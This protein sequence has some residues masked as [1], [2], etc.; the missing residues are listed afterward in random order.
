MKRAQKSLRSILTL[1][2]LAFTIVP[3]A[4]IS[5]YTLVL[6]ESSLNSELKKRLE[7]NVREVGVGLADLE[8]LIIN[9]A[10]NIHAV[11]P[12]LS[13]HVATRNIQSARRTISEWLR[14]PSTNRIVLFDREGRL[15]ISQIRNPNGEIKAQTNLETGDFYLTDQ[16]LEEINSKGQKTEREVIPGKGLDLM[17][18]TRIVQKGKTVGYI[19]EVVEL[20]QN[21]ILSLKKRLNLEAVIFDDKG[22]PAAA[23]NPDFFLYPKDFF[24]GKFNSESQSFF[25]LTSRGEPYGMIIRPIVDTKGKPYVTLGLATS[26][27]DGQKVLKR[28]KVTL[29]T[30][31]VLILLFLIPILFYVSNR[32]VKPLNQ[33]VEAT[34]RMEGGKVVQNMTNTSDTE[35]GI[36]IDSFNRMAKNISTARKE[37]EQKVVELE[38][39][40]VELKNTQTSLVHSAKMASLGQLVAGV[41]HELNNP[42]GFIYSNMSH[43]REYVEKLRTVLDTAEKNPEKLK[44]IKADVEFDFLIDDLPKLIASCEDGARRTRD[45]VLGLRNFSRLDEAQLK[46]VDL[47]EGLSNTLKL[48]TSELKNRIK[49]HEDYGKLPEVRCYVSQLN[50]VFMNILSNAAQAI[51]KDG[52]IWIKTWVEDKWAF[53]TIRDSGP[54]ISKE[55][56]DKI[57]DPFFTTKPVGRGTGLGLSITYGIMQKHGGEI[58]VESKKGWGTE[59]KIKIPI[60]GPSDEKKSPA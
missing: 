55:D 22:Q 43:L 3:L 12:T 7:G 10:T 44:K 42:I 25:D 49:L 29:L 24:P 48:L 56:I 9:N 4:F 50:Q 19:E 34:Q 28:I 45:I 13:Y 18:Y 38:A 5:G 31:T 2:F 57:F 37:L 39:I 20:G 59:F 35:I 27:I 51:E 53:V 33:L 36:L 60:D 52:E 1:W 6:Y 41:A 15:I 40:N 8:R 11:D 16:L 26:K 47:H 46:K 17:V 14:V 21:F 32:V 58:T 30:V 23:S 54:G